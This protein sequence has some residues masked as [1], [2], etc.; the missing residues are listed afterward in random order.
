[1]EKDNRKFKQ[2]EAMLYNYNKNKVAIKNM[3][4]DLEILKNNY[5][6]VKAISYEEKSSPT[7]AFNSSVENEI[8]I[9][10]KNTRRLINKIRLK[11]IEIEKID[12]VLELLD[13]RD[14][15]LIRRY[16]INKDQLKNISKHINL[17]E[18]YLSTYKAKIINDIADLMFTKE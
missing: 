2:V 7:N 9:R 18:S 12:N 4:L 15:Y 13:E 10:E 1:M 6:G 14:S 11:E 16:Y 8:I 17:E 5:E 3:R